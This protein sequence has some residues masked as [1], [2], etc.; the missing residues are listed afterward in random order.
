M[1]TAHLLT[2]WRGAG[3]PF[4]EPPI[5]GTPFT[6]PTFMVPP[7]WTPLLTMARP[8]KDGTP[9]GW[10][11]PTCGQTNTSENITFPRLRLPAVTIFNNCQPN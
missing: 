11:L 9:Q 6:E 4:T 1:H 5:H 3:S 10:Y 7:S 8:A 2:D